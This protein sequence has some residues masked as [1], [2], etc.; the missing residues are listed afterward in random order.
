MDQIKLEQRPILKDLEAKLQNT[1]LEDDL[2]GK[3]A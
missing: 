1:P 2:K 3:E